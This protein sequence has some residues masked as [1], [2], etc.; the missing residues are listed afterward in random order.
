MER[1]EARARPR[2]TCALAGQGLS[3]KIGVGIDVGALIPMLVGRGA[4]KPEM[5][6]VIARSRVTAALQDQARLYLHGRHGSY[7][8]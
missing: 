5:Q 2:R 1:A 4:G 3:G 7:G 6:V 8:P